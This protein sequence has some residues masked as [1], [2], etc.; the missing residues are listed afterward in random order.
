MP[1]LAATAAAFERHVDDFLAGPL[2]PGDP[3]A[4]RLHLAL[5]PSVKAVGAMAAILVV[6]GVMARPH[7]RFRLAERVM[8][9]GMPG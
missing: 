8:A 2:W 3:D 7:E 1:P 9:R 6:R 5:T 4:T